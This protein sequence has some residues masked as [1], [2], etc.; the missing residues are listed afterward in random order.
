[1]PRRIEVR[2]VGEDTVREVT[3]TGEP[4]EVRV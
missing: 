3:F 1:M 2:V 4:I